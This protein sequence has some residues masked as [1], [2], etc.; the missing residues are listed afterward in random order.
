MKS[1]KNISAEERAHRIRFMST[2][3][4][5]A[6]EIRAAILAAARPL[7]DAVSPFAATPNDRTMT[8]REHKRLR[9][10]LREFKEKW[11]DK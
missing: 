8:E 11:G 4:Q 10:V 3:K 1:G 2:E 9:E 5:I 7:V 6:D